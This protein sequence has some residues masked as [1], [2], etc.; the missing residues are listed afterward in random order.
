LWDYRVANEGYERL[1]DIFNGD[2]PADDTITSYCLSLA[3]ALALRRNATRN[4]TLSLRDL[5]IAP[6]SKWRLEVLSGLLPVISRLHLE[7][8][9]FP[10]FA[11]SDAELRSIELESCDFGELKLSNCKLYE[12][13]LRDH[14]CSSLRLSGT[15]TFQNCTLQIPDIDQMQLILDRG[16]TVHFT[17]CRLSQSLT[18]SIDAQSKEFRSSIFR[19]RCQTIPDEEIVAELE[20]LTKGGRFLHR[21]MSLLKRHGKSTWGVYYFKLRGRTG[22]I[23]ARFD[24]V[25][26]VLIDRRIVEV[27]HDAVTL[28]PEVTNL[29]F[30]GKRRPGRPRID[31]HA[32]YWG[33]VVNEIDAILG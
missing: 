12:V 31:D 26:Q 14:T 21:L 19:Q 5:S 10:N 9:T 29:M 11:I 15:I 3:L 24:R 27:S 2:Q 13:N 16:T 22:I 20:G 8:V 23:E 1:L 6:S 33:P 17:D 7:S 30:D 32:E 25:L 18:Q 28:T 4:E